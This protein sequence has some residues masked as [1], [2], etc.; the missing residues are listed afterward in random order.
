MSAAASATGAGLFDLRTLAT[1][2]LLQLHD[3]VRVGPEAETRLFCALR[4]I[5]IERGE[6]S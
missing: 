1:P 3:S 2:T 5:L 4:R 6:L